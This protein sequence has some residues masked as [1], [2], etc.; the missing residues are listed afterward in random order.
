MISLRA[1][2][3]VAAR[4]GAEPELPPR[5]EAVMRFHIRIPQMQSDQLKSN[6]TPR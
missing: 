3:T 1:R 6:V 5:P 2:R 4:L